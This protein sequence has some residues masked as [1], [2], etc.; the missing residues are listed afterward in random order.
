MSDETLRMWMSDLSDRIEQMGKSIQAEFR[1]IRKT[2]HNPEDCSKRM[3]K[4]EK[5]LD[6]EEKL[7]VKEDGNLL[8]RYLNQPLLSLVLY[9]FPGFC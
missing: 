4:I 9:W 3:S 8:W 6:E 5:C 2:L 7:Q 1:K